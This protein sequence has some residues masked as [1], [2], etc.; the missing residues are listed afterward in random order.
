MHRHLNHFS[1]RT[2]RVLLG[3]GCLIALGL[4]LS[5]RPADACGPLTLPDGFTIVSAEVDGTSARIHVV[6]DWQAL[7]RLHVEEWELERL[8]RAALASLADTDVRSARLLARPLGAEDEVDV[9]TL[10]LPIAPPR[11]TPTEDDAPP[12]GALRSH[13]GVATPGAP[14]PG[15]LAG[16]TIYLSPGHGWYWSATLGRWAS[17]RGNTHDIVEDFVNAE[18]AV[19]FLEP[20]LRGAGAQVI[21]VR[22]LDTNA[23][24]VIIDDGD[25]E[26]GAGAGYSE[27]GTWAQGGDKG[28]GNNTAPY[29]NGENPFALG[30]YRTAA[31]SAT[32][33][34][35][36][37]YVPVIPAPGLYRVT[38]G[39]RSG[40]N[41]VQD[42]RVV[43]RHAGGVATF[44]VDQTKHGQSWWPLGTFRFAAG[45]DP[46]HGAVEI[47]ND[48]EG[49][50]TGKVV[51][52]D[53]VR[54]GGGMGEIARGDGKAPAAAPTTLRPRW[55][56]A[57]RYYTQF[58]GAPPNVW[59]SSS[60]DNNDDVTSRSR[61]AGWHQE[62]GDDA[63][64]LSW[65]S[66][67]PDPGRGTSTYI[68]G[69][70]PPDGSKNYQ[71]TKGS[72]ELGGWLQ[73]TIVA[74]IRSDF[75]PNWKDRGLYSAYFGEVNPNH[76]PKMPAALV[77]AAFH[78]TK[79]DADFLREPRF[80]Y[81]LARAMTKAIIG[82]FTE[83]DGKAFALPPEPPTH[84]AL[85]VEGDGAILRLRA[86]AI[87]G[88]AGHAPTHFA[89]ERW[90]G[91]A[92]AHVETV[93]AA[94]APDA[95]DTVVPVDGATDGAAAFYRARA[96]NA[97]G[98]SLPSAVLGVAN[99]CPG[100][101]R[102]LAVQGFT[103]YQA[104]Q[105]PRENLAAWSLGQVQRLRPL[106]VNTFDYLMRHVADLAASGLSVDSVERGAFGEVALDAYALIDWAAGEQS[107]KD[108][109]LDADER[110]T[111]GKWLDAAQPRALWLSGSEVGWALGQKGDSGSQDWLATFFGAAY[112]DDDA[113]TYGIAPATGAAL[114]FAGG[115]FDDG[116]AGTYN[117]DW[118]DVF[119]T[120]G[121][122]AVL[123]YAGGT[124]GIAAISHQVGKARTVLLGFPLETVTPAATRL[125]LTKALLTTVAVAGTAVPCPGGTSG[126]GGGGD[127][128]V[129]TDAGAI[130]AGS[131][132][133]DAGATDA[134]AGN[135]AAD[136]NVAADGGNLDGRA[137]DDIGPDLGVEIAQPR[138][139][140][141]GCGCSIRGRARPTTG[142]W[143]WLLGC[144]CVLTLRRWFAATPS[145]P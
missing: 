144:L 10:L 131:G 138:A 13:G 90:N 88:A 41:R 14:G 136:G 75:D 39:W 117:V 100:A 73:K 24:Q 6:V 59:D 87:G 108:G 64:Y 111:L 141:D 36:A 29:A 48:T 98:V 57:A 81:L 107:T 31:A 86:G 49:D 71:A 69:P 22:E 28:F 42:A 45:I 93:A 135:G 40:T 20:L 85:R 58:A 38:I 47:W 89:I 3:L 96:L 82:Y 46:D 77:E 16:K 7:Q 54:F 1:A 143:L 51:V 97:A 91:A 110:S 78:S 83:R 124:G 120:A 103:R 134:D 34:A 27:T 18:G 55:E 122:T 102:A 53:V 101:P 76:N 66:N 8:S 95:N 25:G 140:D 119:A 63:V 74:D 84:V 116:T 129:G 126:D 43:V 33:T 127:A 37:R 21:G 5:T 26:S 2:H 50:P 114:A 23:A 92:F 9:V 139:P 94:A 109:V 142:A 62:P 32:A 35:S 105:L 52:A 133:G 118:P 113:E 17:Q 19:H 99:G 125:A 70:N 12:P 68:Y 79:A 4:T 30:S 132:A 106:E 11:P 130:D 121:G 112:A 61:Y 44:R 72:L 65:H 56:S 104:S 67:A 115:Q 80:R 123:E 137:G 15:V 60:A 145:E 128:G